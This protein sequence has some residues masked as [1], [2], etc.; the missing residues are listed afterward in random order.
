[1]AYSRVT[2]EERNHIHRWRQEGLGVRVI[3]ALLDRSPSSISREL[4]RNTGLR[5]YRP[6]RRI[7]WRRNGRCG[8]VRAGSRRRCAWMRKPVSGRAGRRRSSADVPA[9]RGGPGSARRRSTSM[10]TP[11]R[12]RG[13]TSGRTCPGAAAS[14]VGAVR[15]RRAVDAAGYRT[16]G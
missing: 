5:G 10:S 11:T 15:G 1:M 6:G 13:A 12:S 3:A 8:P 4:A 9:W 7:A 16:S 14:G 2:R